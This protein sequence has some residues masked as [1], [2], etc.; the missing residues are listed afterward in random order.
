M[1]APSRRVLRIFAKG[2]VDVRDSLLWSRVGDR[3]EWNGINEVLRV[4]HP[5]SI[6]KVRHETCSRLD[7]IPLP[8]ETLPA[9]PVEVARKLPCHAYPADMQHRTALFDAPADAVVFSLQADL[10][11]MTMVRHRREGWLLLAYDT[12]SWDAPSKDWLRRECESVGPTPLETTLGSLQRLV[13]AVQERLGAH[14][15]V[16]NLSPV[17]PGER[18][19][20]WL[21]ADDSLGLRVRR[22]N[23]ALA[24]LS[25]QLGFSVVDVERIAACAGADRIKVDLPHL[26]PEGWKLVAEEVVRILE[27][28]GCF[29]PPEGPR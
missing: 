27:E 18:I 17:I 26:T 10:L 29:D 21:G 9:P 11:N 12:A 19:H 13:P 7:L 24:E 22:F 20:C 5:G 23:L 6:A 1:T 25:A 15:L 4:R 8:G 14:V 16:Y 3:I 2:N 28:R